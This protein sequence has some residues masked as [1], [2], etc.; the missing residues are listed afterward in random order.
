MTPEQKRIAELEKEIIELRKIVSILMERLSKYETPKNSN[1]S[2]VPPSKDENRPRHTQSLRE[3]TGRKPGGQPGHKGTTLEMTDTPDCI[4]KHTPIE[5]CACGQDLRDYPL[6]LSEQRQIIDL[7]I[8]KPII[9]EHRI[10]K[11][12]CRCGRQ[13][14]GVFPQAVKPGI[15]YGVGV[16]SL[17]G[18]LHARQ[19]LPLDR[20]RELFND[21]LR[22]PISEGGLHHAIQR[23]AMKAQPMHEE[24]RKEVEASAVVGTD[25]TGSR[26]NGAKGWFWTWQNQMAT[27]I[28]ASMNRGTKTINHFFPDGFSKSVFVHDCWKSHFEPAAMTHQICIAHLLREL[29]YFD[30]RYKDSWS[31]DMRTLLLDALEL[32]KTMTD[33]NASQTII[34]R[35]ILNRRLANLLEK[36][37]P[38]D[39]KE[40]KVFQKRLVRYKEYL[41]VFLD[42]LDVPPDNNGSE[43]AIRNIKV[44]QKISGY[45][46]TMRGAE[47]F[48]I[49]RSVTDTALKKNQNIFTTLQ[50]IALSKG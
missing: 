29:K 34:I 10:Y 3:Q 20:M 50:K 39:K 43:R 31:V 24:I 17:A 7:P 32:K 41:F 14:T 27:F 8:I 4:E 30:Q 18:Y 26:I 40:M 33:P 48:A 19:Y 44:K 25:E 45:F 5:R 21:V 28:G 12:V 22:V 23:M 47:I 13:H 37:I 15:G 2:S 11:R 9:T 49:L 38:D 36:Q 35:N 6:E 1:N 46:K 42:R 16:D